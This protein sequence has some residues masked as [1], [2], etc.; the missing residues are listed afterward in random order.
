MGGFPRGQAGGGLVNIGNVGNVAVVNQINVQVGLNLALFSP[1][2]Q[3]T[4]IQ[5]AGNGAAAAQR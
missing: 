3:Q 1:G 4:L 2:A 5:V